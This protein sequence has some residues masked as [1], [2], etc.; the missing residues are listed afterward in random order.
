[1]AD[2]SDFN[3]LAREEGRGA[4]ATTIK[5]SLSSLQAVKTSA[6]D[7]PIV[8]LPIADNWPDPVLVKQTAVPDIPPGL[9]PSWIGDMA[10]AVSRSTQTPP[11]LAVMCALSVLSTCLQ[12]RFEVA[13]FGEDHGHTET[14]SLWTLTALPSGTRKTSVYGAM[15]APLLAW[16][17]S[18]ADRLRVEIARAFTGRDIAKRRIEK[19]T[20][21]A[22]NADAEEKREA[23]RQQIEDLKRDMPSEILA[24]RLFTGD[25][26]AE[27]LQGLLAE[28]GERMAVLSDEGGMFLIMGGIYSKGVGNIDVFLQ[29]HAGA[30]MRVDRAE[31]VAH[32]DR[33]ALAFGMAIQPGVLEDVASNRRFR[34]SGLLAR[35]LFAM[36]ASNIGTR[37][38]RQ[39]YA[40][41]AKV[42]GAYEY[43]LHEL[44]KGSGQQARKPA[45]LSMSENAKEAWL[46]FADE[47]E[48]QMAKGGTLEAIADWAGKLPGAAARI[49]CLFEIAER[50]TDAQKV[51]A[52]MMTKAVDMCRLLIPHAQAAFGM[53]GADAI[54]NDARAI[55]SWAQEGR[56]LTFSKRTCQKA[57]EGRFRSVAKLD[58]ALE[59][60]QQ[61][62]ALRLDQTPNK[63]AR[64]STLIRMN[65]KLFVDFVRFVASNQE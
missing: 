57:M 31:R 62:D 28:H 37:D 35:F 23:I 65:P 46:C 22:V 52:D 2:R 63:G 44:L 11:V 33:P 24:P 15:C 12:R 42:S 58:K 29:G 49:A 43:R 54:D 61:S 48:R 10:F 1:M 25:C 16:E 30:P 7:Q 41:P 18:E 53:I 56:H 14:L 17:K 34:D 47:I 32:I 38:V 27:R 6:N 4:V 60:L 51:G 13:P 21:A 3:D 45:V 39:T 40:V 64:A 26:T 50:G 8:A 9:L 59:R 20:K 5:A 19:L 36:P 55:V